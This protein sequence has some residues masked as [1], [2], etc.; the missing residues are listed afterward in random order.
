ME[1]HL[2]PVPLF[3]GNKE[4]QASSVQASSPAE[5]WSWFGPKEARVLG[6]VEE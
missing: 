5:D 1:R 6:E 2:V 3:G 4:G